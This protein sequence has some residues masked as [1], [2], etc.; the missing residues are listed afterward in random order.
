MAGHRGPG[1]LNAI[2]R[3]LLLTGCRASEIGSLRWSE[4]FSDRI[5]IA[6]E[7]VKKAAPIPCR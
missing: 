6:A 7:R 2:V 1:D 3:L 4:V 5:V